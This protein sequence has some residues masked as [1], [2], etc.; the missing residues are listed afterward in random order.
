MTSAIKNGQ[1]NSIHLLLLLVQQKLAKMTP[2][3][4]NGK[5]ELKA[6]LLDAER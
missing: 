5:F 3:K 4:V 6:A 2:A 1:I